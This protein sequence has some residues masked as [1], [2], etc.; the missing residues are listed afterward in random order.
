MTPFPAGPTAD[1]PGAT[2]QTRNAGPTSDGPA[3][4]RRL[5]SV[6]AETEDLQHW[7]T[8]EELGPGGEIRKL[9]ADARSLVQARRVPLLVDGS[10]PPAAVDDVVTGEPAEQPPAPTNQ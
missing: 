8:F 7:L 3:S 9:F 10:P 4:S 2:L 6:K 5:P 1:E